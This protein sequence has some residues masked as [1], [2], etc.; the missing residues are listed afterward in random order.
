[1]YAFTYN[2]LRLRHVSILSRSF[3]TSLHQTSICKRVLHLLV[4]CKIPP[5]DDFEKIE[6]CRSL[7]G[8]Y[9]KA[10]N[11]IFVPFLVLYIKFFRYAFKLRRLRN[12][13]VSRRHN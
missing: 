13:H 3:S 4:L 10:N 6:T 12:I 8:L 7:S 2:P 11:L 5:E 9:V 1:M